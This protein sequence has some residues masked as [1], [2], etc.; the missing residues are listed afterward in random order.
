MKDFEI[1]DGVLKLGG[2]EFL[3]ENYIETI[4][5]LDYCKS[6][7][8]IN[9][10]TQQ[11]NDSIFPFI[12]A[13]PYNCTYNLTTRSILLELTLENLN[14]DVNNRERAI[15]DY[16]KFYEIYF[17]P[18]IEGLEITITLTKTIIETDFGMLLLLV[19]KKETF[20]HKQV[21]ISKSAKD[22]TLGL[23]KIVINQSFKKDDEV[24]IIKRSYA[25][26]DS[27][28]ANSFSVIEVIFFLFNSLSMLSNKYAIEYKIINNLHYSNKELFII[29]DEIRLKKCD[30]KINN[31]LEER[32]DSKLSSKSRDRNEKVKNDKENSINY[33]DDLKSIENWSLSNKEDSGIKD[34]VNLNLKKRNALKSDTTPT[35]FKY[36]NY[37]HGFTD[38]FLSFTCDPLK[39]SQHKHKLKLVELAEHELDILQ[40]VGRLIQSEYMF[41]TSDLKNT[42][43]QEKSTNKL[44]SFMEKNIVNSKRNI[45]HL[46]KYLENY[47]NLILINKD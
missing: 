28:L 14:V 3:S 26:V 33:V 8:L 19:Q 32:K 12:D 2:S 42:E 37:K 17:F 46:D 10:I 1:M 35:V 11:I 25:K 15:K 23:N 44:K 43:Y 24:I 13:N 34:V 18:E 5:S 47:F 45:K 7:Q 38:Y 36:F 27:V 40:V 20:F 30:S 31:N 29:G 9:P 22:K 21:V 6:L 41:N 39:Q 16:I 4:I